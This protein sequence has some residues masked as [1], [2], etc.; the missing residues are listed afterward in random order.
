MDWHWYCDHSRA[1]EL[2]LDTMDPAT[3]PLRAY[4]CDSHERFLAGTC[5]SC[6][7][8]RCRNMG[9]DATRVPRKKHV[10]MYLR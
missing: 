7:A 10:K 9:I 2:F 6:R 4:R 5:M 1:Y 8:N 3:P